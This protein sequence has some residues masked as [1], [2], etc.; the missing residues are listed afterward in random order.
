MA[1]DRQEEETLEHL[2]LDRDRCGLLR[3]R[4]AAQVQ[5]LYWH[6]CCVLGFEQNRSEE[7]EDLPTPWYSVNFVICLLLYC[8]VNFLQSVF[9]NSF[10]SETSAILSGPA[11]RRWTFLQSGVSAGKSGLLARGRKRTRLE[12]S[13]EVGQILSLIWSSGG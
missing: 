8:I 3:E 9:D 6:I 2:L 11:R 10:N 5:E 13:G 1:D 4:M 7:T 12:A